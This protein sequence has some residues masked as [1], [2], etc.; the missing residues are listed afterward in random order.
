MILVF[1]FC[2]CSQKETTLSENVNKT[3]HYHKI[4]ENVN[5]TVYLYTV[6]TGV[7]FRHTLRHK[8]SASASVVST[9]KSVC[10]SV[11]TTLRLSHR[12]LEMTL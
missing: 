1:I 10:L 9:L 5:I 2:W 4:Y 3:I 7:L 11:K 12:V 6:K 8:N